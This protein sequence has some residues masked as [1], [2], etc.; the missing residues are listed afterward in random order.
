MMLNGRE[1]TIGT[2]VRDMR[3]GYGQVIDIL[4]P[5]NSSVPIVV[6]F[7]SGKI[8]C[9]DKHGKALRDS[10]TWLKFDYYGVPTV[11]VPGRSLWLGSQINQ[12]LQGA[13]PRKNKSGA[14]SG[15]SVNFSPT[16][17]EVL[18]EQN[19]YTRQNL[20]NFMLK[21]PP[22]AAPAV[23]IDDP[24]G[25]KERIEIPK[26]RKERIEIPK[27]CRVAATLTICVDSGFTYSL[28]LGHK[29]IPASL[30]PNEV[31]NYFIDPAKDPD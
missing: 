12:H 6:K 21:G 19:K 16:A 1:I 4:P 13:S 20:A 10:E 5:N 18:K 7:R 28:E 14:G 29:D 26:A 31:A 8:E 30:P 22:V 24:W 11:Y 3:H 27:T 15:R 2:L 17:E 9:Y 25:G 23:V